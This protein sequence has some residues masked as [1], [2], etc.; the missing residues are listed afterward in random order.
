[1]ARLAYKNKVSTKIEF[2]M[3]KIAFVLGSL[4]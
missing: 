4:D 2:R 1:M 3:L